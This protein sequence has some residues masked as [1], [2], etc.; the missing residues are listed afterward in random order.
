MHSKKFHVG[1]HNLEVKITTFPPPEYMNS[2][3]LQV[4]ALPAEMCGGDDSERED[5]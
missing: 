3:K 1:G 2:A 4:Q 5:P